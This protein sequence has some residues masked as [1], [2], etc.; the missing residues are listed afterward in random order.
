MKLAR[1][2]GTLAI[3]LL[4][5]A[6]CSGAAS[7]TTSGDVTPMSIAP[8]STPMASPSPAGSAAG[9]STTVIVQAF[10]SVFNVNTIEAPAH[11]TLAVTLENLGELPHDI[12]FYDMEGGAPLSEDAVSRILQGGETATI[13]FTTPGPGEYFFLCLVHPEMN[14]KFIVN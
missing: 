5:V 1:L 10:D 4:T 7:P 9:S 11:S 2:T 8:E 12:A 3:L 13:S 6:A 14:G